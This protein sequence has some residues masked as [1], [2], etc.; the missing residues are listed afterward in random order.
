MHKFN[1][2]IFFLSDC[3]R[4]KKLDYIFHRKMNVF[5]YT[6]DRDVNYCIPI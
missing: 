2:K 6:V 4:S 1:N 3:H 5:S